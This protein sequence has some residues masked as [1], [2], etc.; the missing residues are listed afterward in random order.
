MKDEEID[1]IKSGCYHCFIWKKNGDI[2]AVGMNLIVSRVDPNF[3]EDNK[4]LLLTKGE[5][6]SVLMSGKRMKWTVE[7][8]KYFSESFKKRVLSLLLSLKRKQNNEGIIY[9]L[10]KY[11]IF[12]IVKATV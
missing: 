2:L 3:R 10:P 4:P 1:T 11:L 8:H 9:K 12:I 5:G 6:L 7:N